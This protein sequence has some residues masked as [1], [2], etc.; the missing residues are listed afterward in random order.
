MNLNLLDICLKLTR[1]YSRFRLKDRSLQL[2]EPVWI[3]FVPF[4]VGEAELVLI[5]CPELDISVAIPDIRI[6]FSVLTTVVFLT[7]DAALKSYEYPRHKIV[8]LGQELAVSQWSRIE[9][10]WNKLIVEHREE[11]AKKSN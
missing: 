10:G 1:P 11:N 7:W 8:S 9:D 5:F 3:H 6:A 2:S 4:N